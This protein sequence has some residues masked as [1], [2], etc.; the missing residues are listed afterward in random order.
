MLLVSEIENYAQ[1][2]EYLNEIPKFT[3]KNPLEETRKFYEYIQTEESGVAYQE[4][5]LGKIIHV[6]GTNGKGSVCAFLSNICKE[7]GLKTG[8]FSSPHLVTTRE[9]FQIDGEMVSEETFMEAFF[10]FH[11]VLGKYQK[12]N[13]QYQPSYFERLFFMMI[14]L[15]S[16]SGVEIT[17]L[18]TGLGGRMDTTN[19]IQSPSLVVITEIGFDHMA[20]LGDTISKIAS[21]KAGIIKPCI[22]VVFMDRKKEATVEIESRAKQLNA[23]CIKVSKNEYKITEIKKKSIDF[24]VPSRYYD[25]IGFTLNTKA[26][27]QLENATLAIR[28]IEEFAQATHMEKITRESIE[29]GIANM[30]WP[31]RMEEVLP[32]VYIDGAHNEDGI[33][34]FADTV[35]AMLQEEKKHGVLLF[36][37]V[38]DKRYENMI[39]M[40]SSI[41]EIREFVLTVIPG[42]RGVDLDSLGKEFEKYSNKEVHSFEGL[43]DAM[44]YLLKIKG[45]EDKAFIVGSLYLAGLVEEYLSKTK[46]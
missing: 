41:E 13:P 22:P 12:S 18:E 20:Y 40:L 1:A 9:R 10:Q 26:R 14:F 35:R 16:K 7:S 34:A 21:E 33:E 28:A 30:F 31:G 17:V 23:S 45:E 38:N 42:S 32:D 8:F 11:H 27:Y 44:T 36:S 19:V 25:Y 15:F 46:K 5:M 6:A 29:R 4:T 2:E 3:S 43:S 37:V 39:Q 24:L